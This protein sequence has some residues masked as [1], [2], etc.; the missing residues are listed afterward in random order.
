M[1]LFSMIVTSYQGFSPPWAKQLI[2]YME[3]PC[4]A[5]SVQRPGDNCYGTL[6]RPETKGLEV[7]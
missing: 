7:K 5:K 2:V 3:N 1:Y 6:I 4:L